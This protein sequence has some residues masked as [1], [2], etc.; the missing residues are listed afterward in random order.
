V[1]LDLSLSCSPRRKRTHQFLEEHKEISASTL[2]RWAKRYPGLIQ[3]V[4]DRM[5]MV[6]E[7]RYEEV[8]TAETVTAE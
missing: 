8:I 3:R 5:S 4:G 2:Y 1:Q 7:N 6:D